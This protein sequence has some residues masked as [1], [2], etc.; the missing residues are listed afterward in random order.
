MK[1][2][3]FIT[4][5]RTGGAE[6]LVTDLL[7]L[8]REAGHD[9]SLL[10]LDGTRTPLYEELEA[11][12]IH[13]DRLSKGTAAMRNPFLVFSLK[14]YLKRHDFDIV[15]SHNTSCQLLAATAAGRLPVTL[16]TTEHNTTNRRRKWNWYKPVD[17]W[18]YR[19]YRQIIC[20]GDETARTLIGHL[21]EE[22]ALPPVRVIRNG[23]NLDRFRNG[24]PDRQIAAMSGH[25]IMMVAAFRAQ[26][27]QATLIRALSL[28]PSSYRLLL[29]GGAETPEDERSLQHC[30]DLVLKLGLEDRVHFLGVRSDVPEI[31]AASDIVV[32][33]S[34]YE[35]GTPLAAIEGMA[36][37]KPLI[38][39]EAEGICGLVGDAAPLFPCGDEKELAKLIRR[40]CEDRDFARHICDRC[41][42]RA[43][44]Y[45][46]RNTA[47]AYL[48][49]Y[50][51]LI[52]LNSINAL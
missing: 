25:K 17:R 20:V 34:K 23:I 9:T 4:S 11:A 24:R 42:S 37:G 12:G 18:M 2:L 6:R 28:L 40:T 48:N 1:I 16:V 35:G 27:D 19:R 49:T 26:K 44:E 7:P 39:S 45:D 8:F 29:A 32:L 43:L 3:H 46:I 5:L 50:E 15:H 10:L 52:K 21:G 33:S 38:A 14:R 47:T 51:S 22:Q 31:L 13:I 41:R 36:A 30:R